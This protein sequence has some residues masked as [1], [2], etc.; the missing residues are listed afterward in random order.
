M[1]FYIKDNYYFDIDLQNQLRISG[2][3]NHLFLALS[4]P[5]DLLITI[6]DYRMVKHS[7]HVTVKLA[8]SQLT[9]P[10][11]IVA[12]IRTLRTFTEPIEPHPSYGEL[13]ERK[14]T[15]LIPKRIVPISISRTK[16]FA[17]Y[18][19]FIDE[20][21][22]KKKYGSKI[23]VASPT[24]IQVIDNRLTISGQDPLVLTI[25]TI[26]NIRLKDRI[27][28]KIFNSSFSLPHELLS[29][30]I[31][32]IYHQ[33]QTFVEHLIRSKKTSSFEYGTIFPRDWIESADLGHGDLSQATVDYM[34]TQAMQHISNQGEAWHE[35]AIGEFRTKLHDPSQTIDRKMIDIEPRYILGISQVSKTLLTD[36]EIQK[37]LRL[38]ARYLI[39]QA[40][41]ND[42]ISFK[43]IV[44]SDEYYLV[45]N[46]RDSYHA[47]PG[48][49]SPLSPYDVN[50]VLYPMSLRVIRQFHNFFEIDDLE[51]LNTLIQ[52]WDD[53][54]QRFRLNHTDTLMGYAIALHGKK[55]LPLSIAHLDESYDLFYGLPSLEEIVS[56]A[57]KVMD[58]N[59]FYTPVG[60]ILVDIDDENFTTGNYHGKVIWPKQAAYCV[61]GLAK[62]FRR[63]LKEGWPWPVTE[64]IKLAVTTTAEACFKGWETLGCVPELYYYDEKK[65]KARL[66]T[67]Q[68]SYEGQMSLIQLWS[69]VG[70][71]RIIQEYVS[72]KKISEA[73]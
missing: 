61:I 19:F 58:P 8:T 35:N 39:K 6:K 70:C 16:G 7:L 15:E 17:F 64:K 50:C 53:Q 55:H 51:K 66:Y 40:E 54:K 68:E 60:P 73:L 49:K 71:R 27:R 11:P 32:E 28:K 9:I 63:G 33:S 3:E 72:V 67:D 46:W 52:K 14:Q 69:S 23:S 59:F 30:Q 22:G 47:Y 43:K 18:N 41:E 1:Q 21:G 57:Q 31:Q 45:G 56:F 12:D 65:R 34:Y 2:P 37:K 5:K 4:F 38:V 24:T 26:T 13:I 25:S 44:N 36:P 62:Q 10:I 29:P 42:L 20:T 48:Q